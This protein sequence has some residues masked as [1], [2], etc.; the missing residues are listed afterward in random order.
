MRQDARLRNRER[1]DVARNSI[2]SAP[3]PGGWQSVSLHTNQFGDPFS[4]MHSE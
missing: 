3:A 2:R 1:Q 4:L